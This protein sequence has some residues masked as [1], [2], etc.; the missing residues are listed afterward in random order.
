MKD[1]IVFAACMC[2]IVLMKIGL[3]E[4]DWLT[5][6][7]ATIV[8]LFCLLFLAARYFLDGGDDDGGAVY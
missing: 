4:R 7:V 5:V 6:C 3:D 1:F 8:N 2:W